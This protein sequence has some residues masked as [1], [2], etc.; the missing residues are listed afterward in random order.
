MNARST[1]LAV[2]LVISGCATPGTDPDDSKDVKGDGVPS[3]HATQV[4]G[5]I[6]ARDLGLSADPDANIAVWNDAFDCLNTANNAAVSSVATTSPLDMQAMMDKVVPAQTDLCA[7]MA[8][9]NDGTTEGSLRYGAYCR[10]ERAHHTARIIDAMIDFGGAAKRPI[11]DV[12]RIHLAC[13]QAYEAEN[14]AGV[15]T[16]TTEHRLAQC[17]AGYVDTTIADK[18]V[19]NLVVT[20]GEDEAAAAAR[21][22]AAI[23]KSRTEGGYDL[24]DLS[25]QAANLDGAATANAQATCKHHSEMFLA[26]LASE[27]NNIQR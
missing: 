17:L 5:C 15:D 22:A 14:F 7:V 6:A 27:L 8:I 1:L 11:E 3:A 23:T 20:A 2:S 9:G 10:A 21:V 12:R 19:T 25:S 13:F 18:V 24:C 16:V 26:T 4:D